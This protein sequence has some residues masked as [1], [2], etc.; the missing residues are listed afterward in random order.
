MS[1][2]T[3]NTTNSDST[4]DKETIQDE[5]LPTKRD[6]VFYQISPM[7][8]WIIGDS[9]HEYHIHSYLDDEYREAFFDNC[10]KHF[11][12]VIH[13]FIMDT[14]GEKI[15]ANGFDENFG[16]DG[17]KRYIWIQLDKHTAK[18]TIKA[19]IEKL[20][21]KYEEEWYK[22]KVPKLLTIVKNSLLKDVK[23]MAHA[24]SHYQK[25]NNFDKTQDTLHVL[26]RDVAYSRHRY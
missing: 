16:E 7:M 20:Q 5:I 17:C 23:S 3:S 10:G 21:D 8:Q 12:K 19:I 24:V 18:E 6:W 11:Y 26:F 15:K 25:Q 2:D 1:S 13:K 4:D 22:Y 9:S 14:F